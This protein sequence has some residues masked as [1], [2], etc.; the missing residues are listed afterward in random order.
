MC[1]CS[2][3]TGGCDCSCE[4]DVQSFPDS[5][6]MVFTVNCKAHM[7]GCRKCS[8]EKCLLCAAPQYFVCPGDEICNPFC[9]NN[10]NGHKCDIDTGNYVSN[11]IYSPSSI[12][13]GPISHCKQQLPKLIVQF[14][15]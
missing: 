2:D 15:V 12:S 4:F 9:K 14:G 6:I 3:Y 1:R 5:D 13:L 8:K 10:C 11:S 7:A